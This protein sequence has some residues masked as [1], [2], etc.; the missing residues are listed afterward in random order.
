MGLRYTRLSKFC[1]H[2]IQCRRNDG[3]FAVPGRGGACRGD[4]VLAQFGVD[5]ANLL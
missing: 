1:P 3:H 5:G 2:R 4:G